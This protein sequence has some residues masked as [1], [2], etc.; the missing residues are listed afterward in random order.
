MFLQLQVTEL[1]CL[2]SESWKGIKDSRKTQIHTDSNNQ[3]TEAKGVMIVNLK[4]SLI[5]WEQCIQKESPGSIFVT[6][7]KEER[8]WP[9]GFVRKVTYGHSYHR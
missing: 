3:S 9:A 8:N 6:I 7:F 1:L 4:D 2:L 5:K